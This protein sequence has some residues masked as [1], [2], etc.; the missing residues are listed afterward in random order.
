MP[1]VAAAAAYGRTQPPRSNPIST[2]HPTGPA[3]LRGPGPLPTARGSGAPRTAGRPFH[4]LSPSL[5]RAI[6]RAPALLRGARRRGEPRLRGATARSRLSSRSPRGPT[7]RWQLPRRSPGTK[8][9]Q[10]R[11]QTERCPP[12][13]R[14]RTRSAVSAQRSASAATTCWSAPSR[15]PPTPTSTSTRSCASVSSGSRRPRPRRW[16]TG[17]RAAARR[18]AARRAVKPSR[19]T[20]SSQPSASPR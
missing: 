1:W 18:R 15:G 11:A 20:A 2:A 17:W 9:T 8:A 3:S 4:F 6:G 14:S 16:R 7:L 5:N 10:Q 12:K 13:P 19:P